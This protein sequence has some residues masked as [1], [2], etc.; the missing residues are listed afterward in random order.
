MVDDNIM[1][2]ELTGVV[3]SD[4][5]QIISIVESKPQPWAFWPTIGF[6]AIIG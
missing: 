2:T 1:Y 5:E 6:S 4:S 3:E